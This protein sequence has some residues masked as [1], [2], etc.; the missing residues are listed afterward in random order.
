MAGNVW[1]CSRECRG[2]EYSSGSPKLWAEVTMEHLAQR[3]WCSS[4]SSTYTYAFSTDDKKATL[5]PLS[6]P[7]TPPPPPSDNFRWTKM[8]CISPMLWVEAA[9]LPGPSQSSS[10]GVLV[11]LLQRAAIYLLSLLLFVIQFPPGYGCFLLPPGNGDLAGSEFS[12]ELP[13]AWFSALTDR[14]CYFIWLYGHRI[15]QHKSSLCYGLKPWLYFG[16]HSALTPWK[17]C[18]LSPSL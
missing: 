6:L 7:S 18:S 1:G 12:W 15:D 5:P 10:T 11:S 13:V 4:S 17:L 3:S 8:L 9:P 16:F 14:R 2:E